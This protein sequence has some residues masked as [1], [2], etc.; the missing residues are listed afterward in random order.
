MGQ[1]F[2]ELKRR[3]VF[4]VGIA[5]LVASWLLI[6][7]ADTIFPHIG[8]SDFAITAVIVVL[9]IGLIPALA[10]SWILE[11]TPGGVMRDQ[12]VDRNTSAANNAG[13]KFDFII[14][15]VMAVAIAYFVMDKFLWT[16]DQAPTTASQSINGRSIAVL[17][18]ENMSGDAANEQFTIGIH[19][20][21]LTHISKIGSIK[22]ISRTS[23]LKY[24]DTDKTIPQ[25]ARELGVATI[26]EGGVQRVG[27]RIR[28]NVQLID[29][30]TDE[31]RW[32]ETYNRQLTVTDIFSI[33]TD[34]ATA[35][36][37]ALRATLLPEEQIRLTTVPTRDLAAY[38]SYLLG[39]QRMAHRT[40]ESLTEA[41][42]YFQKAIDLD[43]NFALAYVGLGDSYRLRELRLGVPFYQV[44]DIGDPLI[45]STIQK[46]LELDDQLGEAYTSLGAINRMK[47]DFSA[48]EA[49]YQ[50]AIS[51]SPNYPT[52]YHFYAN[53]TRDV[54]DNPGEALALHSKASELDP[55]SA[56]YIRN[57]G[58]DLEMLGRFDEALERYQK[59]IEVNPNYADGFWKIG[60][61]HW[62]VSGRLDTAVSWFEKSIVLNPGNPNTYS[63][64]GLVLLDL[65]DIDKATS[66]LQRFAGPKPD[67]PMFNLAMQL[68]LIH[69]SDRAAVVKYGRT[70]ASASAQSWSRIQTSFRP[71]LRKALSILRDQELAAGRTQVA[72]TIYSEAY[73][74][75]FSSTALQIDN[76]NYGPAI[77]LALILTMTGEH[78][79]ADL[80]LAL[81][82]QHVKTMPRLGL[83]GHGI[84]DVHIYALQGKD[85]KALLALQDA[86]DQGWRF[87]WRYS[88]NY[89]LNMASL[90][91]KPEFQKIVEEL[92]IDMATQL[93]RVVAN[94][95]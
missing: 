41:V 57:M 11:I 70:Q 40:V 31:H 26:L 92:E 21:L 37:D 81:S 51:L 25:I 43:P 79:R 82:L 33:Q 68:L 10:L 6:Q 55:L 5:Y 27:D 59:S 71:Y 61:H 78:E 90:R 66:W 35:I 12:D 72:R 87:L 63:R 94:E 36:A 69:Q 19:D 24:R 53:M 93:A 95:Q 80:L 44:L 85:Q 62:L 60:G 56:G 7:I 76:S 14:I 17:P 22:T 52:T 47:R 77:D 48:A 84:S 75:L 39:N 30:A 73:P 23:V 9:A 29:A 38:E 28:I 34:I 2:E 65:G 89:D 91:D 54:L 16:F 64:L 20:D 4:R 3:N 32:A 15:G 58:T 67:N 74:D 18:F 8:L 1:F 83:A 50:R 46:A 86:V 88:L 13:R 49:S 42:E 45:E